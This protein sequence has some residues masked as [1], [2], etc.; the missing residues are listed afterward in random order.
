MI[1]ITVLCYY[2]CDNCSTII[3]TNTATLTLQHQ[4]CNT[5]TATPTLQHQHCNTNTATPTLQHQHC[6][7]NTTTPTPQHQHRNTNTA[8]PNGAHIQYRIM[9]IIYAAFHAV[10]PLNTVNAQVIMRD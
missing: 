7:T 10:M 4:H 9:D 2:D 6:N 8:T 5:N 1:V 3:I